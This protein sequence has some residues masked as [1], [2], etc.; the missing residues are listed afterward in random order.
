[1][2]P[3]HPEGAT[4]LKGL[5]TATASVITNRKV[6]LLG[7]INAAALAI[8]VGVLQFTPQVPPGD[9]RFGHEH[10][11]VSPGRPGRRAG[12]RQS[13]RRHSDGA[14]GQVRGDPH[15]DGAHGGRDGAWWAS[16]RACR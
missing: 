2:K 8:G 5:V 4:T 6:L 3:S 9:P 15:L 10:L 11:A 14:L 1:M 16:C 13:A 7:F 12:R